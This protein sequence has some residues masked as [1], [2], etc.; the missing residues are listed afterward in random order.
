[1]ILYWF[2]GVPS[3]LCTLI[4]ISTAIPLIVTITFIAHSIFICIPMFQ[5]SLGYL[6]FWKNPKHFVQF[7]LSSGTRGIGSSSSKDIF[8]T[9]CEPSALRSMGLRVH[10]NYSSSI[11]VTPWWAHILHSVPFFLLSVLLY[12]SNAYTGRSKSL[13]TGSES[14][15]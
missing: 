13:V 10:S 2:F 6:Y 7:V 9:P 14:F 4:V 11:Q 5:S 12:S 8:Q 15:P 1:M 3:T